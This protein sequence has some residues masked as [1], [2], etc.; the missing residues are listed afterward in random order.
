MRATHLFAGVAVTDFTTA[1]DWYERLFACPP[2]AFPTA[3]EALWRMGESASIY[4]TADPERAGRG[5][6]ALAVKDLDAQ[7]AALRRRGLAAAGGAELNGIRTL[8][9]ADPDGNT[10]KLFEDPAGGR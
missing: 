8:V 10:V 4:V 7:R 3:G 9:V 5:L 6:L 1:C 2:S